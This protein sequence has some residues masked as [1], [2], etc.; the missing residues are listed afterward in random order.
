MMIARLRLLFLVVLAL[1]IA[2][3]GTGQETWAGISETDNDDIFVSYEKFVARLNADGD[4]MWVFPDEDN[5][6]GN[7]Y[8]P[9]SFDQDRVYIGDYQGNVYAVDREDGSEIW[10]YEVGGTRLF[11]FINFGGSTD[12]VI[13]AIAISDEV[14]FVPDEQGIFALNKEN[15]ELLNWRLE[16][17][18]A[19]WSEPIYLPEQQ[20]LYVT[21]LDHHFYAVDVSDVDPEDTIDSIE[22]AAITDSI[23]WKTDLNGASAGRATY[24]SERNI[25]FIGTFG[26]E[27]MAIDATTGD[28]IDKYA[29]EGWVWEGPTL[30]EGNLYFGDVDG[31][32]YALT[33][34]DG[35]FSELWSREVAQEGKFRASPLVTEE[36]IVL[37]SEDQTVYAIERENGNDEW[38]RDVESPALSNLILVEHDDQLLVVT[39]TNERD[40][41]VLGLRL[42]NGNEE[43]SYQHED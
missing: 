42:D 25:F 13:G 8:A 37:G 43:W 18:R 4:R 14:L 31:Y 3:C 35:E 32:A 27:L 30:Y 2:A 40:N 23:I 9:A 41:L 26:S 24:D 21:G 6:N 39:A 36:L 29:T 1:F 34:A 28:I 7:F 10:S 20:L 19:I 33:F 22:D 5:R 15:G 11:G 16:T 38:S 17:D 12:R